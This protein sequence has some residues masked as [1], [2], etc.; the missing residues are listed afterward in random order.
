MLCRKIFIYIFLKISSFLIP[1]EAQQHSYFFVYLVLK[2]AMNFALSNK[3]EKF[4][5]LHQRKFEQKNQF[6]SIDSI[7][8]I[9]FLLAK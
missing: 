9:Y 4:R 7:L 1:S 3:C 8:F 6:S 2:K 5:T